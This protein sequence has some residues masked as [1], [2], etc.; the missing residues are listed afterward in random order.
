ME[1]RH[2]GLRRLMVMAY[3]GR[4]AFRKFISHGL[5]SLAIKSLIFIILKCL[6]SYF[7][8]DKTKS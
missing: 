3:F 1:G 4:H 7:I 6:I 5:C 8:K 2:L